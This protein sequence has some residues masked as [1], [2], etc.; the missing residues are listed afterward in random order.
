MM[1]DFKKFDKRLVDRK[2]R[3]G[4]ITEKEYKKFLDKL[5]EVSEFEEM[6]EEEVLKKAGILSE[7]DDD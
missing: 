2:L 5:E 3:N 4:E 6:D 7:N 1:D